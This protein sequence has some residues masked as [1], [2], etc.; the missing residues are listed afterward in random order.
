MRSPLALLVLLRLKESLRR[1]EA[2]FWT[3]VFPAL[4]A[5]A[6]MLVGVGLFAAAAGGAG[7]WTG[8]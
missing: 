5:V 6:L 7:W 1:P 4:L 2:L 8:R 3:F